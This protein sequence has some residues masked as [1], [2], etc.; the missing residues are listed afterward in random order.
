MTGL[1]TLKVEKMTKEI[2][3]SKVVQIIKLSQEDRFRSDI[4]KE[5]GVSE[6]SVFKYQNKFG[7]LEPTG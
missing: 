3:L 7:L 5:V 6:S 4:A 1:N 2:S